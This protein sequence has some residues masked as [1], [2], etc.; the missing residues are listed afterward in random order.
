MIKGHTS[1][2][3]A[4]LVNLIENERIR[5][6]FTKIIILGGFRDTS[7]NGLAARDNE[8][9]SLW[10]TLMFGNNWKNEITKKTNRGK[11]VYDMTSSAEDSIFVPLKPISPVYI[12]H[13]CSC[14]FGNTSP[15]SVESLENIT[16]EN[17]LSFSNFT[18]LSTK[19]N[20]KCKNCNDP[21]NF[22]RISVNR[23]NLFVFIETPEDATFKKFNEW[24]IEISLTDYESFSTGA[25][26]VSAR[27]KAFGA[28][29]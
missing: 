15:E 27:K 7:P 11:V 14:N 8:L 17:L 6:I 20:E 10:A 5:N 28:Y 22:E 26:S 16:P 18:P 2:E 1:P 3:F 25:L 12:H 19:S 4:G 29:L 23:D 9:K 13:S 24:P 21:F